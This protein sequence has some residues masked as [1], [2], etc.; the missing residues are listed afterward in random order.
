M[1]KLTAAF[2]NYANASGKRKTGM[3]IKLLQSV[4]RK[5]VGK[6]VSVAVVVSALEPIQFQ[7]C[8]TELDVPY[9]TPSTVHEKFQISFCYSVVSGRNT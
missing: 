1:T 6:V 2:R 7:R 3:P 5:M 9:P 4:A 8:K